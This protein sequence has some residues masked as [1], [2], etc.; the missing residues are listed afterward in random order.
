ML[1]SPSG[2]V[3][4]MA[5]VIL[6]GCFTAQNINEKRHLLD[7]PPRSG[8]RGGIRTPDRVVNSHLLCR[9]SYPGTLQ[10]LIWIPDPVVNPESLRDS[11]G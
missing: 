2:D 10:Q 9:L 1:G 8:S 4:R 3:I 5:D 11:A 6:T 7:D